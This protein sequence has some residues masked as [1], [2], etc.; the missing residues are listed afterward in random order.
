MDYHYGF[1]V[2]TPSNK[3]F[4]E[5][6][7]KKQ[8]TAYLN[9]G[10]QFIYFRNFEIA[11]AGFTYF[12]NNLGYLHDSEISK[13]MEIDEQREEEA[14]IVTTPGI[15]TPGK[16]SATSAHKNLFSSPSSPALTALVSGDGNTQVHVQHQVQDRVKL[17]LLET[18]RLAAII[19]HREWKKSDTSDI[20]TIKQIVVPV[21]KT[22]DDLFVGRSFVTASGQYE[23][24]NWSANASR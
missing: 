7:L 3:V 16:S 5:Y 12:H 22:I 1:F 17:K 8:T 15:H 19:S 24:Y 10:N 14:K 13:V 2:A 9:N 18:V 20:Y 6:G 11:A 21:R 4:K 23:W